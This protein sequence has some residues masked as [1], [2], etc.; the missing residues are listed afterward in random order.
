TRQHLPEVSA[1]FRPPACGQRRAA[2]VQTDRDSVAVPTDHIGCPLR[3]LERGRAEVDARGA[4]LERGFEAGIVADAARDL[5]VHIAVLLDDLADDRGVVATTERSIEVD[6][7]NPLRAL[8]NP[9]PCGV[10]RV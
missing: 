10:E 3:V 1:L 9:L 2:N 5:D 6:E 4:A 7:V 8:R